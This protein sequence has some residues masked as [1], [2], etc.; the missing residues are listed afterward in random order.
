[1]A[2]MVVETALILL[3]LHGAH[4]Q[5]VFNRIV[6]GTCQFVC[7]LVLFESTVRIYER[8]YIPPAAEGYVSDAR[9]G[10]KP[11]TRVIGMFNSL[12]LRNAPL[13]PSAA[14]D[15]LRVLCMGDSCT[16]GVGV[17]MEEAYPAQLQVRLQ[18]TLP[19][20]RVVVYNGGVPAY[21]SAQGSLYLDMYA[22]SLRPGIVIWCFAHED[23]NIAP[24]S[25]TVALQY[26]IPWLARSQLYAFIRAMLVGLH[27]RQHGSVLRVSPE[28]AVAHLTEDNATLRRTGARLV[29][30]LMPDLDV[31][32][33]V[34][35]RPASLPASG[36]SKEAEALNQAMT[37]RTARR[38]GIPVIDARTVFTGNASLFLDNVHLNKDG[39]DALSQ[40]IEVR[41]AEERLI[42]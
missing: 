26:Y 27:A 14:P 4:K 11:D 7:I 35:L 21:S 2:M 18:E 38:L 36:M 19:S 31:G 30:L 42:P 6:I 34:P 40:F 39:Y 25:D 28:E 22:N 33:G 9:L 17:R 24:V 37:A 8:R 29:L 32:S 16:F 12:G 13:E 15:E 41:L 1:M 5:P 23:S 3:L 10:W 20:R